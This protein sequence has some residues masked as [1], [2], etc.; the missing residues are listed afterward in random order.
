MT[1]TVLVFG[2][3]YSAAPLMQKAKKAGWQV[4]ATYRDASKQT[5]LE[6]DCFGTVDFSTGKAEAIAS[7]APLHILTSIAPGDMGDAVLNIWKNWLE[8]QT[9]IATIQYLSSTNV[10]GD[11]KGKLVD[12]TTP[13]APSLK[14]GTL[15]LEAEAGWTALAKNVGARLFIHRLAGIY[16]PSRNAFKSLHSGR[17]HCVIKEGQTFGRIHQFDICTTLWAAMTSPHK[18]GIF[19]V[20]DD[21]PCAPH[22]VVEAAAKMLGIAAPQR[23]AFEDATL[24]DMARSFFQE[25]K[26][27]RN[28]KI[29]SELGVQL[30]YPT[31][32][33]GLAALYE[34][35]GKA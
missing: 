32:K 28:E 14:R 12:E 7:D 1:S 21:F 5:S 16:G 6:Q 3:G 19:N 15:R 31:Y 20:A 8:Q 10:Y 17:A 22:T 9:N 27:V 26:K 18:G 2:P 13:P 30:K 25:N 24:S 29:K 11:H 33:Q 23:I 35:E 4:F 34:T